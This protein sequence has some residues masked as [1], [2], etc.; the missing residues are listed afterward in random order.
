MAQ[1][2]LQ[3]WLE[4]EVVQNHAVTPL[5]CSR[6]HLSMPA[7]PNS[8]AIHLIDIDRLLQNAGQTSHLVFFTNAHYYQQA[9]LLY[10]YNI[11]RW[12]VVC[13][14]EHPNSYDQT[15]DFDVFM[16]VG[17]TGAK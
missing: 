5:L 3:Q 9:N 11:V 15:H 12:K 10:F 16:Q 8:A 4:S 13:A 7:H 1:P 6:S 17:T 14:A 2:Q